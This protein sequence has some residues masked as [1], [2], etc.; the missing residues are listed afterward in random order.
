MKHKAWF[1]LVMKCAGLITMIIAA[2][3]VVDKLEDVIFGLFQ[4]NNN[5][6]SSYTLQS[7]IYYL[8]LLGIGY[9]LCFRGEWILSKAFPAGP[10]CC[11]ACGYQVRGNV[12]G[13]CSEC[14]SV[15]PPEFKA[16]NHE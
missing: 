4:S 9:Y 5:W 7:M 15:L 14:G 8:V 1:R 2:M 6:F 12:S 11:P 10:K 16:A 3:M 13:V